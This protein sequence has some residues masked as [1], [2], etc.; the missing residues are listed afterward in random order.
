MVISDVLSIQ[1]N[2]FSLDFWLAGKD[3]HEKVM[4]RTKK[5]TF[6]FHVCFCLLSFGVFMLLCVCALGVL[7][8][9]HQFAV[10][11]LQDGTKHE[12]AQ[13]ESAE[14]T[15]TVQNAFCHAELAALKT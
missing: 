14:E 12:V 10:S 3:R 7:V 13:P 1:F 6:W 15:E 11:L 4:P 9:C 8:A 5:P 2:P